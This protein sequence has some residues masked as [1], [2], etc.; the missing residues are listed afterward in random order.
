[1]QPLGDGNLAIGTG[2]SNVTGWFN[3][4]I[5]VDG[6]LGSAAAIKGGGWPNRV[7]IANGEDQ[8]LRVSDRLYSGNVYGGAAS[9][10]GGRGV[11]RLFN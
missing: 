6:A 1:M 2:N 11:R 10:Y 9:S 3:Q 5:D 7:G 4:T 8:S